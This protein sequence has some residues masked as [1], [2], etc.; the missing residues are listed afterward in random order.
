MFKTIS[1]AF[2]QTL[3]SN[4]ENSHRHKQV[5]KTLLLQSLQADSI[6][7]FIMF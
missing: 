3:E 2:F 1:A 5:V 6:T 7:D 4:N